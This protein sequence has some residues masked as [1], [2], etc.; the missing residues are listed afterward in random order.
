MEIPITQLQ[1]VIDAVHEKGHYT[2]LIIDPTGRADVYFQYATNCKIVDFKK[3]LVQ[4][5]IQ[6]ITNPQ[7]VLEEIRT[8]LV[9]GLKHGKCMVMVMMDSAFDF[10]KW[11]DS[12][13]FPKEVLEKGG[14]PFREKHVYEK[15]LRNE[16]FDDLGMFWANEDFPF[17]VVL[18]T[19]FDVDEYQ[20]FL[21][22][23]IQLEKYMPI[24]IK[25]E[26]I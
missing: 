15:C 20:E 19:N 1:T 24:A 4:C 22:D 6:K 8:S 26:L 23:A 17:R 25:K 18:T 12:A 16:D 13:W 2:P 10:P 9:S 7:A 21:E 5:E 11:F 14:I 3:F